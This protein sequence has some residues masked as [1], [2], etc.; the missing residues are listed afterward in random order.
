MGRPSQ[1]TAPACD[2]PGALAVSHL[3]DVAPVR[4]SRQV[5]AGLSAAQGVPVLSY[6]FSYVADAANHATGAL[7]TTDVAFFLDTARIQYGAKTT[8]RD[9]AVAGRISAYVVDFARTGDPNGPGLPTW[10]RYDPVADPVMDFTTDGDAVAQRDPFA[11]P[12]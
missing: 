4:H 2:G 8:A 7:H 6:L 1:T 9:A 3:P 11:P 10:P 5:L 12:P